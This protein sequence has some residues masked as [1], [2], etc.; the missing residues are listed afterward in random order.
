M[1]KGVI[2]ILTNPAFDEYV[3]IGYASNLENRLKTLNNSSALP[4]AFRVYAVYEVDSKLTDKELHKLIDTLNP[5]LRAIEHF[6]GKT[7]TKEFFAMSPEDA[8]TIL[9]CIAKISGTQKSLK[10]MKPEGHE[11]LDE[12]TAKE[13]MTTGPAGGL[14]KPYKG[15]IP[16]SADTRPETDCQLH[17]FPDCC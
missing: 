15:I 9:E 4:Y 2:Y 10:R 6:D 12:K 16:A 14:T 8:Y 17:S 3:K 5:D 13:I 1:S 11:V 7:R